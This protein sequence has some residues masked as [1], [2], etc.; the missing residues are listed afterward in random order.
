[1]GLIDRSPDML[2]GFGERCHSFI[3][4]V[5]G[6]RTSQKTKN[7]SFM[8]GALVCIK[9]LSLWQSVM[10]NLETLWLPA[11]S[12]S[13]SEK[14]NQ[15]VLQFERSTDFTLTKVMMEN[16]KLDKKE[17]E[18][19]TLIVKAFWIGIMAY[20]LKNQI[21]LSSLHFFSYL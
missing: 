4:F 12:H 20:F 5:N 8:T 1:M 6:S 16:K 11:Q 18:T 14:K 21:N 10:V 9:R 13:V 19:R 2:Y 17:E 7:N 3:S 15:G